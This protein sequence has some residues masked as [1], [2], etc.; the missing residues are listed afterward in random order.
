MKEFGDKAQQTFD[1][2]KDKALKAAGAEG[3]PDQKPP[4]DATEL[5]PPKNP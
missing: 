1:E 3:S 2:V 4:G 5:T